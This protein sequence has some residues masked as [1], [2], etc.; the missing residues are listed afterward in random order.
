M[1]TVS[2]KDF[3]FVDIL[4]ALREAGAISLSSLPKRMGSKK[5]RLVVHYD[6]VKFAMRK[7][8]YFSRMLGSLAK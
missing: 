2:S 8:P 7:D 5:M 1:P 6:D 4:T 3:D